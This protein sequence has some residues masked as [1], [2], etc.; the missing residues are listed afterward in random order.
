M[1]DTRTSNVVKNSS[2]TMIYKILHA[3]VQFALRTAFIYLLGAEYT[4]VSS[5]FTD[6]L[7]VL[8]L[9]ELGIGSAMLYAL[10]KPFEEKDKKRISALMNYYKKAYSAIGVAI[11][12]FGAACIPLL[13]YIV[14]DVPNIKEDIRLI[15][16]LYVIASGCSYFAI[17]KSSLFRAAQKSRVISKIEI[18]S[19]IIEIITEIILL[20][21]F[22]EYMA[23]LIVHVVFVLGQNFYISYLAEKEYGEL[24]KDKTARLSK[25]DTKVLFRDVYSL[26]IYKL[27]AVVLYSTDS[28]V[29]SSFVGT[30]WVALVGNYSLIINSIRNALDSVLQVSKP[31]VGNLAVTST[32]ERQEKVF[33]KINFITFWGTCFCCC[34]F[35]SL[36]TPF[37]GKIWLGEA[38]IL[39]KS[40]VFALTLNFFSH[41]MA[42]PQDL[43]RAGN[44]LFVQGKYRPLIMSIINIVLDVILVKQIGILGVLIATSLSRLLTQAWFDPYLIYKNVFHKKP[45]G[46][47]WLYM[48]KSFVILVCCVISYRLTSMFEL[49]NIY[50]D[51]IAKGIIAASVPNILCYFIYRNTPEFNAFM[52]LI[53]KYLKK[54]V[55]RN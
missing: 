20:I 55:G 21:V 36:L 44:G 45:W 17:Y 31:S 37:V 50:I 3:L 54:A 14:K 38:Y 47:Y 28:I 35:C 18:T 19:Q 15:F 5:L 7:S 41:V 25:N 9:M 6:I 32:A 13:G 53:K 16:Y 43:F 40:I 49:S 23:Y 22:R 24:L 46:F 30:T 42:F 4:A 27:S 51:F 1:A 48:K 11:L 2:A 33:L 10:Y 29:I 8:S 34:C 26:S 52:R 12:V 39:D